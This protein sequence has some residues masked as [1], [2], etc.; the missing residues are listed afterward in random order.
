MI[1]GIHRYHIYDFLKNCSKVIGQ[2]SNFAYLMT[3]RWRYSQLWYDTSE[4]ASDK[5]YR[6]LFRLIKLWPRYSLLANF[7]WTSLSLRHHN[8]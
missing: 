4:H 2:N 3:P 6:F 7:G 1:Q 5:V 8:F